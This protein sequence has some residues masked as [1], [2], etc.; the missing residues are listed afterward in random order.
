[1]SNAGDKKF[2]FTCPECYVSLKARIGQTGVR[3]TCPSCSASIVVPDAPAAKSIAGQTDRT[4][5]SS[6]AE[7]TG[8]YD[9]ATHPTPTR[10]A[11]EDSRS[12][13]PAPVRSTANDTGYNLHDSQPARKKP[14]DLITVVCHICATRMAAERK[15]LGKKLRCTECGTIVTIAEAPKS[16]EQMRKPTHID[17]A[18]VGEYGVSSDQ[19]SASKREVVTIPFDC[20]LCG[21]LMHGTNAQVGKELTCPDCGTKTAVPPPKIVSPKAVVGAA[22]GA[23]LS[24]Y[25]LSAPNV[26]TGTV[27]P[28]VCSLCNSRLMARPDQVGTK[29]QCPDCG[30]QTL[31]KPPPPDRTGAVM[32]VIAEGRTTG[33]EYEV[34]TPPSKT[35]IT[36]PAHTRLTLSCSMCGSNIET[37]TKFV[38]SDVTCPD[39]GTIIRVPQQPPPVPQQRPPVPKQRPPVPQQRPPVPKQP[40][41]T[42]PQKKVVQIGANCPRCGTRIHATD[43]QVGQK[44]PCPDC[45]SPITIPPPKADAPSEQVIHGSGEYAVTAPQQVMEQTSMIVGLRKNPAD[46]PDYEFLKDVDDPELEWRLRDRSDELAFLGHPG[47]S[48]R[49]L[50]FCLGGFG[51]F[52]LLAG[53]FMIFG[54]PGQWDPT[55]LAWAAS[56]MS[57]GVASIACLAWAAMF[58]V[59]LLAIIEDTSAGNHVIQNWPEGDWL[60]QIGGA[61]YFLNAWMV[62]FVPVTVLLQTVP[63]TRPVAIYLYTA[64]MW[65][66]FP[67]ALL[68]MLEAGSVFVPFTGKVMASSFRCFGAWFWFY[69]RSF[70]LIAVGLAMYLAFWRHVFGIFGWAPVS[71]PVLAP[72]AATL[73]MVYARWLGILG[74]SVREVIEEDDEDAKEED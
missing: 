14:R 55:V 58:S 52:A 54:L 50:G 26:S 4:I 37:S 66:T 1:M 21:T 43:R 10:S 72:M 2:S 12:P 29:I 9:L 5:D 27:V 20:R 59:N 32:G 28:V 17:D 30:Q 53:S 46:D 8:G 13:T 73:A 44:V 62:S 42:R 45:N 7:E 63:A 24:E 56:L 71:L 51:V 36:Q 60:D 70:G 69:L 67:V 68:S 33:N 41:Q 64:G 57:L 74:R 23:D 40:A 35:P 34:H 3:L 15:N 16:Q 19:G 61:F 22:A 39:C 18:S 11:S 31:V 47:A 48:S 6:A 38:G 25:G 49:W 65:L